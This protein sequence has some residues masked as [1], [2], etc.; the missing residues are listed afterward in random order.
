MG[1]LALSCCSLAGCGGSDGSGEKEPDKLQV[2][3]WAPEQQEG[4]QAICDKWTEDSGIKADVQVVNWDDYWT[5]LEAGAT[6]GDM[7]DVFWMHSSQAYKYMS[8]DILLDMTDRIEES[9]EI[10]LDNYYPDVV[11]L[12]SYDGKQYA[13]PKDIDTVG[14]WY[15]RTMFDEAGLAYPDETWTWDTFYSA[16]EKLTDPE[17]GQY[18]YAINTSNNQDSYYNMIYSMGGYII[19]DDKTKS[20]YDDPNTIK[21]FDMIVDMIQKGYAPEL[22]TVSENG[23]DVLFASGKVAM[24]T[25]GSWMLSGF[26][27][28]EYIVENCDVAVLPKDAETG[29][30]V[31]IYNG[32]GWAASADGEYTEEA[33]DLIEFLGSKE[34]QEEQAAE[35]ITMSAYKGTSDAW[36]ESSEHFNLS[37]YTDMLN[38]ELIINPYSNNTAV[39]CDMATE[40]LKN[41]WQGTE[42]PEE[43][44]KK[45]ADEM[46]T[47]LEEEQ[48]Q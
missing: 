13:I 40:E 46:N 21:A 20:G 4:L 19:N 28:N 23:A 11:E 22:K 41:V 44:C 1:I 47:M 10:D 9:S 7:P 26:E 27:D 24:V 25:Q 16:A 5:L 32:L 17:K 30:R 37:A 29:K 6:G 14:L 39:W 8:N 35:G 2:M 38:E 18:G 34:A 42:S 45:I 48:N 31:S 3:I 15:N 36:A 12:Y 33:W 43:G